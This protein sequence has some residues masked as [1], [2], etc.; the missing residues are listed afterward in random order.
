MS[1]YP[2][3]KNLPSWAGLILCLLLGF[4]FVCIGTGI[5]PVAREELKAVTIRFDRCVVVAGDYDRIRLFDGDGNRYE[6]HS[7]NGK[8]DLAQ[9]LKAV[10]AGTELELLLHP[11]EDSV[12]GIYEDEIP[13][14]GWQAAMQEI[15]DEDLAFTWLGYGMWAL[16]VGMFVTE[17]FSKKK[18]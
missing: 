16:G 14:L 12:L 1:R 7:A 3:G 11:E 8:E 18:K 2:L 17:K 4:V 15:Q 9:K 10:P 6:I 5:K 13:I